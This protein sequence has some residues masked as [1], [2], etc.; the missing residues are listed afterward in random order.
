[1]ENPKLR[2]T[3]IY[4]QFYFAPDEDGYHS[5]NKYRAKVQSIICCDQI[6]KLFIEDLKLDKENN[7]NVAY[8]QE[9]REELE[10]QE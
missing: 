5:S 9:V 4:Q 2:A 3:K 6:L 10:K 1:M 7:G 8:W